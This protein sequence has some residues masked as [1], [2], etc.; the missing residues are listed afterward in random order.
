MM[1]LLRELHNVKDL[2]LSEYILKALSGAPNMLGSQPHQLYNNLQTLKLRTCLTRGCL[3]SITYLLRISPRVESL[4]L[5]LF[6][7][8]F[9]DRCRRGGFLDFDE[10]TYDSG[11]VGNNRESWLLLPCMI[12]HLKLAEIHGIRGCLN[13]LKFLEFLLTNAIALEKLILTPCRYYSKQEVVKKF[14]EKLLTYPRA[15]EDTNILFESN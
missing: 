15:S 6:E 3:Q 11:I 12:D 1:K 7:S 10:V 9:D 2:T 14:H 13:E 5:Q 4:S 8:P